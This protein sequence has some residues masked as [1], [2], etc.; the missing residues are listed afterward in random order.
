[1]FPA[2]L[3]ASPSVPPAFDPK[4]G[5]IASDAGSPPVTEIEGGNTCRGGAN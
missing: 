5:R 3:S 1:M 2:A 4:I